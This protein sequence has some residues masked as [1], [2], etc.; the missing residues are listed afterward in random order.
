MLDQIPNRFNKDVGLDPNQ[1]YA[2]IL[3]QI[4]TRLYKDVALDPS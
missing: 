1:I 2:Q 4:P 3:D